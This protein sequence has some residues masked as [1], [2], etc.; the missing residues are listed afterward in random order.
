VKRLAFALL[1]FAMPAAAQDGDLS[2]DAHRLGV[3]VDESDAA[4]HALSPAW[5]IDQNDDDADLGAIAARFARMQTQACQ[6]KLV[7]AEVCGAAPAKGNAAEQ[8]SA[9]WRHVCAL[10]KRPDLC[11]ME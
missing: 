9:F 3:M 2:I 5:T 1:L 6:A 4:L 10:A 11:V 8:I 7:G